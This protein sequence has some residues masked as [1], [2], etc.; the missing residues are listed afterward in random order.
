MTSLLLRN[1]AILFV[2]I[3]SC[4]IISTTAF[5]P[6]SPIPAP[7]ATTT[8]TLLSAKKKNNKVSIDLDNI[9]EPGSGNLL[10][11]IFT[12][13]AFEGDDDP[14]SILAEAAKIASRI[15]STKDL[16]WTQP[17][18]RRGNARPRHRAWGGEGEKSVQDKP[19]YDE[20]KE[21]CVEKWLT[22]EDFCAKTKSTGPAADAAFVAL[23]GGAKYAERDKC[24]AIV[25]QWRSGGSGGK[26]GGQ[27]DEA[28]FEQ[29]VQAGRTALFTGYGSFLSVTSFFATC[30]LFPTNP[31]N[32]FFESLIS[33][34]LDAL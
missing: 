18:R 7:T 24:E 19:N 14:S 23:A 17:P 34:A 5:T 20:A 28:A 10:E 30:I 32:K 1:K 13:G 9:P 6:T 31:A 3:T 15:K 33:K 8:T 16:G 12:G 4:I 21:M 26:G 11:N 27:F 29:S 25:A 22:I 2:T